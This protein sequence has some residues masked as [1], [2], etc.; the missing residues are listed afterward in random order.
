M[1]SASIERAKEAADMAGVPEAD[2]SHIKITNMKDPSS[3][4]EGESAA[5]LPS[6][7]QV[8][9]M[10]KANTNI[11]G[12]FNPLIVGGTAVPGQ[13]LAQQAHSGDAPHAG[14]AVREKIV[15]SHHDRAFQMRIQGQMGSYKERG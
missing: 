6:N 14:E 8:S 1:E 12:G 2:M 7:N 11:G 13:M 10:M 3:V 4:R 5:I 15:Q 9:Q